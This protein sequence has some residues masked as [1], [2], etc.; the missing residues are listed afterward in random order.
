MI[1][2][3][4]QGI[5]RMAVHGRAKRRANQSRV[6]PTGVPRLPAR[7]FATGTQKNSWTLHQ[8]V[9]RA[10]GAGVCD[11]LPYAVYAARAARIRLDC[12]AW[13]IQRGQTARLAGCRG[14]ALASAYLAYWCSAPS[15]AGVCDWYAKN[16]LTVPP[17]GVP[18]LR[19]GSLCRS[20]IRRLCGAPV[21]RRSQSVGTPCLGGPGGPYGPPGGVQG[22]SPCP[23]ESRGGSA[24]SGGVQGQRPGRLSLRALRS[25]LGVRAVVQGG[26]GA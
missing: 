3:K 9:I 10:F 4:G 11:C 5:L 22:Q 20:P 12:P 23:G 17:T 25:S 6:P 2:G 8:L 1:R 21:A 19:R 18:R 26:R 24:P 15:G 16:Q 14:S 7:E 13:G